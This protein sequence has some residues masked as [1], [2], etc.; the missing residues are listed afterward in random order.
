MF[1]RGRVFV[2]ITPTCWTSDDFPG[3]G[4]GDDI[5]F[6]RCVDEIAKAEFEGCSIGR[7][8]P[9]DAEVLRHE[10]GRRRLR[11]SEPW[12]STYF[13]CDG[14]ADETVG[15]FRARM[16]FVKAVGGRDIG[17]AELGGAVHTSKDADLLGERP[18]FT[19]EQWSRLV[20][21]LNLLGNMATAAGMRLCYH[22]HMGTGVQ[23]QDELT[24]LMERTNENVHLLLDTG[25][26]TWAG[27][28]PLQAV[29]EYGDR[30]AHVHLK[31]VRGDVMADRRL[32]TGSFYDYIRAGI[33]TVPG[34]EGIVD[35]GPILRQ[36][37]ANGYT[38]WLV[39]EAEQDPAKAPPFH[40]AEK[41]RAYLREEAGL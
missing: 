28:K 39:V 2:G 29:K 20:A 3:M 37:E 32:M 41:A 40:F 5:T 31:N 8:F 7:K 33:F 6:E 11:V 22:P 35:F 1:T 36:L 25:H 30:I 26:L 14:R 18:V 16:A 4:L 34:D 38:G 12:V 17:V 23:T 24:T 19:D 10:L 13:T 15:D 21:G 9:Q 27:G